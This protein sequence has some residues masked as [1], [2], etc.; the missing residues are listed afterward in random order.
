MTKET[1]W[2][3][4]CEYIAKNVLNYTDDMELSAYCINRIKRL[5]NGDIRKYNGG[6]ANGYKTSVGTTQ[7]DNVTILYAFMLCKNAIDDYLIRNKDTFQNEQ[8]KINGVFKIV[9]SEINNA[10]LKIKEMKK[11]KE[12]TKYADVSMQTEHKASYTRKTKDIVNENLKDI[13]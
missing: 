4:L 9:E 12:K 10:V 7:Y 11:S 1:S 5:K 6:Y 8:H 3:R 2:D 13:F